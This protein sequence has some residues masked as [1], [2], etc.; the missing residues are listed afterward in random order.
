[1]LNQHFC[2]SAPIISKSSIRLCPWI[3]CVAAG[4][5]D[6]RFAGTLTFVRDS[7][8]IYNKTLSDCKSEELLLQ[9]P[10]AER[11]IVICDYNADEDGFG[12]PSQL[13]NINRARLKAGIFISEDPVVFTSSS[14]SHPGVVINKKE[15]KQVINYV[16][17]SAAP[18]AA[19]TFQETYVDGEKPAP[20]LARFSA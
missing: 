14:F 3:L 4:H 7:L 16:K 18:T 8:V 17:S 6:R 11:T 15:G 13:F 12:F 1:M 20:V 5:T 19:I 2:N 9:V 10:D